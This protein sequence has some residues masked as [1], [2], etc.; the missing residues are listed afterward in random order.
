MIF[1][2]LANHCQGCSAWIGPAT[3]MEPPTGWMLQ[4]TRRPCC[5]VQHN[6]H[7]TA[8]LKGLATHMDPPL[9]HYS[10]VAID[11]QSAGPLFSA[12]ETSVK[13]KAMLSAVT[14]SG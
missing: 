2:S 5:S 1:E 13:I 10:I 4:D 12:R 6:V 7:F 3:H 9:P 14:L 11:F 8:M